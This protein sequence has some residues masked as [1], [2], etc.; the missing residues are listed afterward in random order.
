MATSS[1][2]SRLNTFVAPRPNPT[3]IRQMTWV[4]R[5]L[6]LYGTPYLRDIPYLNQL[7]LIRGLCDIRDFD[8]PPEDDARLKSTINGQHSVF[9]TPNHPEFFT[10][11]MIDKELA[12]RYA[13]MTANWAT[14]DIVNGMGKQVQNF[15]LANHLIAQIPGQTEAAQAYSI[16]TAESGTPVLLHPEGNVYWQ[17][18]YINPLFGGAAKMALQAAHDG[19]NTRSVLIQPVVW[20]LKFQRDESPHLHAEMAHVE[21]QLGIEEQAFLSLPLRLAR[22]YRQVLWLRFQNMGFAPP[23]HLNFFDAQNVLME[24]LLASLSVYGHFSG[25]LTEQAQHMLKAIRQS[26]KAGEP[27][28]R[29]TCR[30]RKE[31]Q[32]ILRNP[33]EVYHQPRWQQ[34]TIA[35][36]LKRLRCDHL[37]WGSW[38][39]KIHRF[40]PRPVGPRTAH[41]R[42]ANAIDVSALVRNQAE[43]NETALT[44]LLHHTL[45][46]TLDALNQSLNERHPQIDYANPFLL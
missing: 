33:Q 43:F 44:D 17:S 26:E 25:N 16:H 21:R 35:E 42:V 31:L 39:N 18:D 29:M 20:K 36:C 3:L 41:I 14:H 28:D 27:I 19:T 11:W 15:W 37:A 32:L 6:N 13:P 23:R 45:Q 34:E 1:T 4:N 2:P 46:Q 30:R 7:P 38:I 22:L 12:A 9:I 8:L 5:W 40:L 10:D 24:K